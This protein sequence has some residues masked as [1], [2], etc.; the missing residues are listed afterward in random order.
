LLNWLGATERIK[1]TMRVGKLDLSR[2]SRGE[3]VR[4]ELTL[5]VPLLRRG[6]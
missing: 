3:D 4:M 1:P 6:L 5:E 2:G